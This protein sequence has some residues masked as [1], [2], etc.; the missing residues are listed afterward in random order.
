MSLKSI[1]MQVALPRTVE[2]G[3]IQE[4]LQQRGQNMNDFAA[5]RIQKEEI[6]N[7]NTVTK[8]E[9]KE[10]VNLSNDNRKNDENSREN[11]NHQENKNKTILKKKETHPYKGN[12][13][14]YSG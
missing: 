2:V 6:Q 4:Q 14:D 13:I 9:Q 1:E 3:K 7:R 5:E 10:K 8:Q 11:D 12:L